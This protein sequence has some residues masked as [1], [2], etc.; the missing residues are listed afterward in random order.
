[1]LQ[2]LSVF[3]YNFPFP[4][5]V[6]GSTRVA[7]LIGAS[8]PDAGKVTARVMFVGGAAI[9][10]ANMIAL[11]AGREY[12]PWLFTSDRDVVE[13]AA[14]TLPVNAAFQLV[15]SLAAQSN[16][17]LRGLGKQ[18]FGGIAS[19]V[20]FYVI[21]LPIS[22]GTGFGLHWELYGLWAG[23]AVGLLVQSTIASIYIYRISWSKASDEAAER[24]EA[25]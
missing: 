21:A 20:S 9:G 14:K 2:S 11:M 23:P 6:A 10:I 13:L 4:L 24:N 25:G 18:K 19:L 12:I 8:L 16:G 15:D 22:F 5:A 1:M 7:N 17:V 3:T